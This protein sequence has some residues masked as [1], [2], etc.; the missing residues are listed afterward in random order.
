VKQ[1][2]FLSKK[3]EALLWLLVGYQ[4]KTKKSSRHARKFKIDYRDFVATGIKIIHLKK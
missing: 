3:V 2:V 1:L 4:N